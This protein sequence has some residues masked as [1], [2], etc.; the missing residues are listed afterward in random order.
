MKRKNSINY[1]ITFIATIIAFLVLATIL[2][3]TIVFVKPKTNEETIFL[4]QKNVETKALEVNQFIDSTLSAF[5][6]F[7]IM[8][9][10]KAIDARTVEPLIMDIN[11]SKK[12][13]TQEISFI[14]KNGFCWLNSDITKS[15]V[16]F[17][18]Y[19]EAYITDAEF[20]ISSPR[21]NDQN[22]DVLLLYYP[23]KGYNEEKNALICSVIP[24][25]YLRQIVDST[26][27]FESK[28]WI[29]NK[30]QE[31]ISC[32]EDYIYNEIISQANL[33]NLELDTINHSTVLNVDGIKGK[34]R[35]FISPVD[36]YNEWFVMSLV[37]N[38]IIDK[39]INNIIYTYVLL[40]LLLLVLIYA[41]GRYLSF[42]I[43][44]PIKI[45][46]E[47]MQEVKDG[48][49][50]A[51]YENKTKIHNEID[52]LGNSFNYMLDSIHSLIKRIYAEEK[53]RKDIEVRMMN[54]QIK[55]HFLYNTLDNIRF[56]AKKNNDEEV[57]ES[58]QNL[59]EY[60]RL[61]LNNGKEYVNLD[62][63]LKHTKSYLNM[64]KLRFN[65]NLS[66]FIE[67]DEAAKDLIVPKIIIQP[68]VEN[69]IKHGNP[70][71]DKQLNIFIKV[72][73]KENKYEIIVEDNG[74]GIAKDKLKELYQ[75]IIDGNSKGYGLTNT[76]NRLKK[77]YGDNFEMKMR[78]IEKLGTTIKFIITREG[79]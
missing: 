7:S 73:V 57:A 67:S 78:S 14:G 32:N 76:Y 71:K 20:V 38:K 40:L 55:P 44:S 64:Q 12:L 9:E 45:L 43:L 46:Q 13:K 75:S 16:R 51:Y 50:D 59:S 31:I 23:I 68:I 2:I 77:L 36:N 28:T 33:N 74:E 56:L 21:K 60:F 65:D 66:Y 10:F 1:H 41:L 53:N 37:N 24:T 29:M 48:D 35:L 79:E 4:V 34:S 47:C 62:E 54:E 6:T 8:P 11:N 26:K 39:N 3:H 19:N 5:R 42:Y 18:E 27:I 58:I 69:S 49:L 17:E 25:Y 30:N 15:L 70:N 61:S 22:Q 72:E 63:E 52:D